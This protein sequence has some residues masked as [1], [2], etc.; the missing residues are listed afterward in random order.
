MHG[1]CMCLHW[2]FYSE[3]VL[4][5]R[6]W[7]YAF[8][9]NLH[10]GTGS[11]TLLT[12]ASPSQLWAVYSHITTLTHLCMFLGSIWLPLRPLWRFAGDLHVF[13][14]DVDV[15]W[16]A[17]CLLTFISGFALV[18]HVFVLMYCG[19]ALVYYSH[20]Q[21]GDCCKSTTKHCQAFFFTCPLPN[22]VNRRSPPWSNFRW[23]AVALTASTHALEK[24]IKTNATIYLMFF[25]GAR[26]PQP[27]P[28]V[29]GACF[30][31]TLAWSEASLASASI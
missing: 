25:D 18:H 13:V 8:F 16:F 27:L 23:S 9:W 22:N 21:L 20:L 1:L 28:L 14:P 4:I 19:F 26:T 10:P 12:A 5:K 7:A 2:F 17:M 3:L 31:R 6:V 24:S 29:A 15:Y 30:A 11:C